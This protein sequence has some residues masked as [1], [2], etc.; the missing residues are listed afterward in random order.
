MVADS[1]II[2][3]GGRKIDVLHTPGYAS[4]HLCFWEKERGYLFTDDLFIRM[5]CLRT[6]R[7][8]LLS[9]ILHHL[10]SLRLCLRKVSMAVRVIC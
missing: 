9:L 4:V 8:P 5:S 6:I 3:L 1:D 7:L 2:N 10:K